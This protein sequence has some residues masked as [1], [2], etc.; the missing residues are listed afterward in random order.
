MKFQNL[1]RGLTFF[2]GLSGSQQAEE[3]PTG[4]SGNN[5]EIKQDYDLDDR[6]VEYEVDSEDENETDEGHNAKR[7][8]I[9]KEFYD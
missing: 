9:P 8:P 7:R 4:K 1:D 6:E 3:N 2:F 5:G